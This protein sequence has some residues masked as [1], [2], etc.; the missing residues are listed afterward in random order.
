MTSCVL[1]AL[2]A[3]DA[4]DDVFAAEMGIASCDALAFDDCMRI[5]VL[6]PKED[7]N[8]ENGYVRPAVWQDDIRAPRAYRREGVR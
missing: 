8:H 1:A 5:M 3:V 6:K 7:L 4:F 2:E